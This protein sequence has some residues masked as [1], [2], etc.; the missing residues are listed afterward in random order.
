MSVG[1]VGLNRL[2]VNDGHEWSDKTPFEFYNWAYGEPNDA[3]GQE[4]CVSMRTSDG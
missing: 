1:W 2:S 4:S 3:L